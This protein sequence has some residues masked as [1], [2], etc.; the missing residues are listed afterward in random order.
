MIEII[1]K[2]KEFWVRTVKAY[3]RGYKRGVE[4]GR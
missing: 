3:R 1:L 4:R 2:V